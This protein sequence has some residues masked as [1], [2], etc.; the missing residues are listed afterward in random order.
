M[1]AHSDPSTASISAEEVR[2]AN[3]ET[4]GISDSRPKKNHQPQ[5]SFLVVLAK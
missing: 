1:I 4:G 2:L 5:V 3:T